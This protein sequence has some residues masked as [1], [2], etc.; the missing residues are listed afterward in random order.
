MIRR[1]R[2][3][4]ILDLGNTRRYSGLKEEAED[5]KDGINNRT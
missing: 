1:R 3:T 5:R 4:K 2:R